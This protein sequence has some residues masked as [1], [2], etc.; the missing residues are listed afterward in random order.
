MQHTATHCNTLQHTATHVSTC[1]MRRQ[2]GLRRPHC[3]TLQHTATHCNILQ[4]TCLPA[5]CADNKGSNGPVCRPTTPTASTNGHGRLS[6]EAASGEIS[7]SWSII[8]LSVMC[9][10]VIFIVHSIFCY[11]HSAFVYNTYITFM[12]FCVLHINLPDDMPTAPS[13]LSNTYGSASESRVEASAY[14]V[15]M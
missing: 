7:S 11:I 8:T 12:I 6:V 5:I 1:H 4:H 9:C 2:Q 13:S 14:A 10:S 3:N 15:E